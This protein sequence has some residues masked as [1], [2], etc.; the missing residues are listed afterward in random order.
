LAALVILLWIMG[1]LGGQRLPVHYALPGTLLTGACIG[2]G[3]SV[4]TVGLM[5]FKNARHAHVYLDFPPELMGAILQRAPLWA[6][7]GSFIGLGL[8][9]AWMAF[10]DRKQDNL[11]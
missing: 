9:L 4:A 1:K 11:L 7:A 3:A 6:L 8:T 5:F 10:K 2:L